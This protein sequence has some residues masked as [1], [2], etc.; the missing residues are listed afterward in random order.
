MSDQTTPASVWAGGE[1]TVPLVPSGGYSQPEVPP[2]EPTT[3]DPFGS[4]AD[5]PEFGYD[6]PV[7]SPP[8][9]GAGYIDPNPLPSAS[10]YAQPSVP[11]PSGY[12]AG[13][14]PSQPA[15]A[16]PAQQRDPYLALEPPA[17]QLAQYQQP[18]MPAR[19]PLHDPV[20][21]DY[22][23]SRAAVSL[24]EHPNAVLSLVLGLAGLFVMPVFLSPIAWFLAARGRREVASN[25]GRWTPGGSLTAGLVL[26]ILGTV[27]WGLAALAWV[28]F[29]VVI[30]AG[31]G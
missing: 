3:I 31:I 19:T 8:G 15:Y 11:P 20:G 26:G 22:G 21:Y 7:H 9:S 30:F 13:Y 23:Y 2:L 12:A 16:E 27:M 24:P 10:N 17:N 1:P 6:Q 25:P 28:G 29:F 14:H 18:P 5:Y 4:S